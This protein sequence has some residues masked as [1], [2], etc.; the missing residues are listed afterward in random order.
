MI[1]SGSNGAIGIGKAAGAIGWGRKIGSGW[2]I[3]SG[4]NGSG[5]HRQWEPYIGSKHR[6]NCSS[7]YTFTDATGTSCFI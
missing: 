2:G 6:H 7:W 3:G 5:S 1:G 4:G